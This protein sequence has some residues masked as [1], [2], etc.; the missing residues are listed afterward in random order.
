M[1]GGIVFLIG[2]ALFGLLM[3]VRF[4]SIRTFSAEELEMAEGEFTPS[5]FVKKITGIDNVCERSAVLAG[6]RLIKKKRQRTV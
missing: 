6:G 2:Y 3:L 4:P 1:A 5:P